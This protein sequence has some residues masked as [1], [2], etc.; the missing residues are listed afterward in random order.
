MK[1]MYVLLFFIP[2]IY[3]KESLLKN[4]QSRPKDAKKK[5][6]ALDIFNEKK[7]ETDNY[8]S[9]PDISIA[10]LGKN[11][12]SHQHSKLREGTFERYNPCFK[13]CE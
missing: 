3:L 2:V 6:L 13:N 11:I 7:N 5:C 8:C 4:E 1:L 10:L 12:K 9:I